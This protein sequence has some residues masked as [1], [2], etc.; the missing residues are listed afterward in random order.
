VTKAKKLNVL[1]DKGKT[2]GGTRHQISG[3]L[4]QKCCKLARHRQISLWITYYN[5]LILLNK[6]K[7]SL[8][9]LDIL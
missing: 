7:K 3:I 6:F 1:P 9:L 8:F 4:L 2:V 5:I